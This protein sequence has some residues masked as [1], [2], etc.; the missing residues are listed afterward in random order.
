MRSQKLDLFPYSPLSLKPFNFEPHFMFN[1]PGIMAHFTNMSY[2]PLWILSGILGGGFVEEFQRVFI[3]TRFEKWKGSRII[4]FILLLDVISFGIGHLYQGMAGAFSAGI[5][6]LLFGLIYLRKRSF[7]EVF[8]CHAI[9]DVIGI[10][11]GHI[12]VQP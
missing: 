10:T 1:G 5:T 7:I 2:L 3:L 11:I 4:I 12:I 8:V 9:Y 6:G